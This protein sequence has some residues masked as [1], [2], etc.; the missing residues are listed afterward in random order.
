MEVPEHSHWLFSVDH[1][2]LP[3]SVWHILGGQ[4]LPGDSHALGQT[5]QEEGIEG[6]L[7]QVASGTNWEAG[8]R[9]QREGLTVPG[10]GL[11]KYF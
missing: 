9:G 2:Q 3:S 6:D 7:V 1:R 8:G 5:W 10:Q 11:M 4:Y